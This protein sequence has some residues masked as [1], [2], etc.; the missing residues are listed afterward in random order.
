[1]RGMLNADVEILNSLAW[2]ADMDYI[3]REN[4]NRYQGILWQYFGTQSG[5]LKVYPGKSIS[6]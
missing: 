1:M 6:H 2:T 5:V 3:W 4:K